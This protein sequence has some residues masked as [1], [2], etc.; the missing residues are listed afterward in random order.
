MAQ[1]T[2]G[3]HRGIASIDLEQIQIYDDWLVLRP[4]NDRTLTAGE[5]RVTI[6]NNIGM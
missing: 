3:S 4:A 1:L 2:C 6:T 5:I